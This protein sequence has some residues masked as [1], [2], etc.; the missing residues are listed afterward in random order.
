MREREGKR[1]IDRV[2]EEKELKKDEEIM[3][4]VV[5]STTGVLGF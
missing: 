4:W 2:E 3:G 1:G 5:H